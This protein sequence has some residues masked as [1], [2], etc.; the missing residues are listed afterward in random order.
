MKIKFDK[1]NKAKYILE[2]LKSLQ[3]E[4]PSFGDTRGGS[5]V[6]FFESISAGLSANGGL[7]MPE[8]FPSILKDIPQFFTEVLPSLS[9]AQVATLLQRLFISRE[10]ISDEELQ[11]M[12]TEAYNFDI[13]IEDIDEHTFI[14]RLDAGPT[15]SFKDFAARSISRL[16]DKYSEVKSKFINIIVATSGD[17]GVAI[18]DAFGGAKHITVTVIYPSGGVSKV[19]EKQ[20]LA[21]GEKYDNVQVLP[22]K[23]NFDNCQ[24][25]SKLL[26]LMREETGIN[27]EEIKKQISYK[28]KQ[29][30]DDEEFNKLR[31]VIKSLNLSSA[32][33][34]NIWR[35][36]PQ[37]L[38]YFVSY[39]KLVKMG[40]IK[41]GEDVVFS[42]P[43]GNVGHVMAGIFAKEIGLPI[44]KFII[45]TNANNIMANIIGS[46]VVKHKEFAN[47]SAPSMDI[48]DPS[49]L[50]RLL[51][52]AA[53][54]TGNKNPIKYEEMKKDI[55]SIRPD[56]DISLSA[57]GV[58]EEI[59]EYLQDTIWAEDVETN[60][61]IYAMM[62]YQY[63]KSKVVLEPHGTTAFI[64][65]TRMREK[66]EL[67]PDDK[68]IIFET[69]HPD[70]F[71]KSLNDA[72]LA[73]A[74]YTH[75]G[76]LSKLEEVRIEDMNRPE[77]YNIDLVKITQK[78]KELADKKK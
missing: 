12:M 78:I 41:A 2:L 55:K 31:E 19:Q 13:P 6:S 23:G 67:A 33:S 68:V 11:V 72:F 37:M 24:D 49:N 54:K 27:V 42:T 32:N 15:A 20:M 75:H 59:L 70:K 45:G 14:A 3:I 46:G 7:F 40:K 76:E 57:Y 58:T 65:T 4:N 5:T 25:V 39:G 69:A 1:E 50:E 61:E 8:K 64:A 53:K 21:V 38:Q 9:I 71:P 18:A 51:Y 35:L 17:T 16:L 73:D 77:D 48:L 28:L 66:K 47:T 52:F 22:M 62:S 26:Q 44:R 43:T 30:I 74:Q 56:E 60:E 29:E 63:Q 10:D 34:I 36:I